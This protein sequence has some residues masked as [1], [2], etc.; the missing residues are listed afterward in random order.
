[1]IDASS[2][3]RLASD[4]DTNVYV[5]ASAGTG[6]TKVLCDRF[7]RLILS[8]SSIQNILCL[9]FTN[10]A[11]AEMC[12]RVISRIKSWFLCS[13]DELKRQLQDLCGAPP[14]QDTLEKAK[15]MYGQ[16]LDEYSHIKIQTIHSLCSNVLQQNH[17]HKD[18]IEIIDQITSER[19]SK[20]AI[21]SILANDNH[22]IS[23]A[24]NT[25]SEFFDYTQIAGFFNE[26]RNN[27]TKFQ[28]SLKNPIDIFALYGTDPNLSVDEIYNK[29]IAEIPNDLISAAKFLQNN[30]EKIG[31][32]ILESLNPFSYEK[33]KLCFFTAEGKPRAKLLKNSTA[34][35]YPEILKLLE[36]ETQRISRLNIQKNAYI[37]AKFH[38]AFITLMEASLIEY[39]NLKKAERV[40]EY[41]DLLLQTIA[42]LKSEKCDNILLSLDYKIDHILVD[43]AQDLSNLQ[44]ELIKILSSEFYSG[45]SSR[46]LN[47]TIFI[48]GDY[49]QSIYGFQGAN[50]DVFLEI[51]NYFATIVRNSQ[52]KWLEVSLDTSFRSTSIILETVDKLFNLE[53]IRS[54][55]GGD[56]TIHHQAFRKGNGSVSIWPLAE[57]IKNEK[58]DGWDIPSLENEEHA[59]KKI[60]A[61]KI[62]STIHEWL[63]NHR[64]LL[65]HLRPIEPKDILILLKKRS[66]V[67]HNTINELKKLNIPVS[68]ADRFQITNDIIIQDLLSLLKFVALPQDDLNLACLLK[69]PFFGISEE[70]LFELC[71]KRETSVWEKITKDKPSLYTK[72]YS[73]IQYS[74]KLDFINFI[75]HITETSKDPF[76]KRFGNRVNNIFASF[77]DYS[78][79]FCSIKTP[80]I[81]SFIDSLERSNITIKNEVAS[82][83]NQVRIMT[84]HAS[85]GLQ[86]PIVILADTASSETI[87][88]TNIFWHEQQLFFSAYKEFDTPFLEKLK[89]IKKLKE[90]EEGLRLLYVA[91]TRAED[92]LYI[93]GWESRKQDESWFAAIKNIIGEE[94]NII[95]Q[96][97]EKIYSLNKSTEL[98]EFLTTVATNKSEP[99]TITRATVKSE[100]ENQELETGKIV[101]DILHKITLIPAPKRDDFINTIEPLEVRSVIKNTVYNYPE[102]FHLNTLSEV[103]IIGQLNG[104]N[105]RIRIDKIIHNSDHIQI[106]DFKTGQQILDEKYIRQ[107]DFYRKSVANIWPQSKIKTS[108]LWLDS[109]TLEDVHN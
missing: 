83:D 71:H 45:E 107:L 109:Q 105:M 33:Y 40:I 86:A 42:L 36:Q 5:S 101:H 13:D 11:A 18:S 78:N 70:E 2:K 51:K 54:G 99:I 7:L 76:L 39:N 87:P 58:I 89:E 68:D 44:W 59:P 14:S 96:A 94:K 32:Q 80:N 1:M 103:P 92:E 93:T 88:H 50:P 15:K 91:M 57:S 55:V 69:S 49:K 23:N 65:G 61:K 6:K 104:N 10:A 108:I 9:T 79:E 56:E 74:Q 8:G 35:Q 102:L 12:E 100:E 62:A 30:T 72:L 77:L 85:K 53:E 38:K 60:I 16:Y 22:K 90:K 28:H 64:L 52:K 67:L 66:D 4:P 26:I 97:S 20:K 29:F 43:E 24:K 98:P 21:D 73:Y 19:L 48:V 25:L 34:D 95:Y 106:I 3:Q 47:R 84:V 31:S 75:I 17:N 41:E 82:S 27:K 81:Q 63:S 37:S 46:E